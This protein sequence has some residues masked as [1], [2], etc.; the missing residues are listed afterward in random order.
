MTPTHPQAYVYTPGIFYCSCL[1]ITSCLCLSIASCLCLSITFSTLC[2]FIPHIYVIQSHRKKKILWQGLPWGAQ[3]QKAEGRG[4]V[5]TYGI[6]ERR[7]RLTLLFEQINSI[8]SMNKS[9][10]SF[11]HCLFF[12]GILVNPGKTRVLIYTKKFLTSMEKF[13]LIP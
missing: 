2:K 1:S 10:I 13:I 12:K 6:R 9:F 4:G 3:I 11:V 7:T 5:I 8:N